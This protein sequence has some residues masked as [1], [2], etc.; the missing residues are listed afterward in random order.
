MLKSALLEFRVCLLLVSFFSSPQISHPTISWW[1]Q[2]MV[3]LIPIF[4]TSSSLIVNSRCNYGSPLVGPPHICFKMMPSWSLLDCWCPVTLPFQQV[5]GR[6]NSSMRTR[7]C[8]SEAFSSASKKAPS[9]HL[10][11]LDV[12]NTLP[13]WYPPHRPVPGPTAFPPAHHPSHRRAPC[14]PAAPSQRQQDP[15]PSSLLVVSPGELVPVHCS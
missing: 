10:P 6:L 13:S 9:T 8:A 11:W 3:L 4:P 7:V 12:C 15:S 1:L 2:P 14:R 5:S